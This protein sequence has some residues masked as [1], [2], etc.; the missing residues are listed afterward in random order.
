MV[1]T[2]A[3]LVEAE[4]RATTAFSGS[5]N[6][7]LDTVNNWIA[8]ITDYID[9]LSGQSWE[10]TSYT[11]YNDYTGVPEIFLENSPVITIDSL[12]Y[13]TNADGESPDYVARTEDVDF[14]VYEDL[15]QV[16]F[17]TNKFQPIKGRKKGIKTVYTAGYASVPARIQMLATQMVTERTLSSLM[18]DNL[19]SRNSGGSI[20]VGSIN[21]VEPADYGVGTFR[22]LKNNIQKLR[23]ELTHTNFKV[24]RYG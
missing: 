11:Q 8:E 22:E 5:T 3:S 9:G 2:T 4:L 14:V 23:D 7:T 18:N 15:G 10:S 24:H 21:I 16:K 6:P 19:E 17:N 1:Y 12:S 20:S 13:N